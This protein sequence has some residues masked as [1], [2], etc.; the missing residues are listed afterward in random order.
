MVMWIPVF[1]SLIVMMIK[2]DPYMPL[3]S[4]R[5]SKL[6]IHLNSSINPFIY[7]Y[8]MRNIRKALRLFFSC[9]KSREGVLNECSAK[10]YYERRKSSCNILDSSNSTTLQNSD[11]K[12]S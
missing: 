8:R 6:M 10:A 5:I 1:V 7:A 12:I 2:K 3:T 11:I 4:Y 9:V